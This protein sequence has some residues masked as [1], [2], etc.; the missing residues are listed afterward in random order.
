M[1]LVFYKNL[2][3]GMS[4]L[5]KIA[6]NNFRCVGGAHYVQVGLSYQ[7]FGKA[8]NTAP[9]ILVNHAL[10]GNSDLNSKQKGWWKDLVGPGKLMDTDRYTV[11]AFNIPGNGYD[12]YLIKNFR[13]F[14][15]R[16]IAIL[17]KQGLQHLGINRLYAIIG[18]SLGGAIGWEMV[19]EY[20]Q[21]S[22]YLIPLASDWKST[23]WMIGHCH[24][25]E[26]ILLN[27]SQPLQDARK[28][29]ML[30]YRTPQSFNERFKGRSTREK[31]KY[32]VVSWLDAHGEKLNNRFKLH[33]YLLMNH[34]LKNHNV[35][36]GRGS[37]E[38][39]FRACKTKIIQIAI[40][41]DIFFT[42]IENIQS[43]KRLRELGIDSTYFEVDSDD[44]HD[45]FLI[46]HEQITQFLNH[47]F[48][49]YE[50]QVLGFRRNISF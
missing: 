2:K 31:D 49:N 9:V 28:M 8:I 4:Q 22:E 19:A 18:G 47:L 46:E 33:A 25:Q 43:N 41:S 11:L 32:D 16:D 34:L 35:T 42:P 44:G 23:D 29:A 6:I 30:F 45:A 7:V 38:D 40:R 36:R 13:D 39:C 50:N 5:N 37:F 27:S 15:L 21:L 1:K 10:T 17:F 14:S 20:P 24:I 12:G 48:L 3:Q 26:N